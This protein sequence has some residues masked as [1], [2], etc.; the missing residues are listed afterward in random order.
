MMTRAIALALLATF[1]L[2]S[3]CAKPDWIQQTLVTVNVTGTWQSF[4]AI[5]IEL[6]LEQQGQKVTGSVLKPKHLAGPIEGT[7]TGDELKISRKNGIFDGEMTVSGD[8][9]SGA[10]RAI[11]GSAGANYTRRTTVSFTRVSPLPSPSSED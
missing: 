9:M 5:Y 11:V 6:T 1:S 2:G 3:G 4:D 10:L 8:E 7:V